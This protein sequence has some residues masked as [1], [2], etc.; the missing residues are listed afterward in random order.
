MSQTAQLFITCILDTLYPEIGEAVV[1]VLGRLGVQVE[2][3]PGQTCCGQPAFNAGLRDQARPIA[4]HTIRLFEKTS[5]PI[6][7]P[8]GSCTAMIRHGY[9]ELFANDAKWLPR[10]RALAERT[11]EFTEYLVDN[12]GVTDVGA[13]FPGKLTYHSSC[14][15][16]RDLGVDR[17]PRALLAA[18]R[19]AELVEL[20]YTDECCG[21]GGVFSAEHP[22]IS[23]EMLKRKMANI[24][25]SGAPC[26]VACDAGCLTNINGG[27]H[28]QGKP[29]RVL[30]IA[31]VL[32]KV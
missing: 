6:V 13:R 12:L 26:V 17:Q 11:Y 10:A 9:P 22:E 31:E 18:V 32:D 24:E 21:F 28:R 15:L 14:H 23:S 25:D 2:F 27:L 7:V 1:R 29:Q 20:P 16:L 5:G 19:E 8:S 4:I 3:P 30:Y